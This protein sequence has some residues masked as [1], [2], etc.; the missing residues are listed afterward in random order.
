L[1]KNC[2]MPVFTDQIGHSITLNEKPEKIISLVPSQTELLYDLGLDERV[3]GITK[4][5]VHPAEWFNTKT[6]VGGTK[7]LKMDLIQQI[8]PDLIIANKEENTKEQ[9]EQLAEHYPV[10]ISDINSLQTAYKMMEA[11]GEITGAHQKAKELITKIKTKLAENQEGPTNHPNQVFMETVKPKTAY[12]I[13][14]DPY[15]TVGGDTFI[16][17]MMRAAGFENI[18]SNRQRY[19]EVTIDEL[20]SVK[21]ELLFLSSEPFP[22]KQKHREELR[23]FLP[24]TKIILVDGEMFS[25]YGSRL[26]YAPEYFTALKKEISINN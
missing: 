9:I 24:E 20:K 19:P 1:Q 8:Q 23:A 6:K 13:W 11:L 26:L 22:F 15:M 7:Q 14:K 16:H 18:F 25:W 17:S 5:C 2:A 10:W 12:L 4:F 3:V 21:C